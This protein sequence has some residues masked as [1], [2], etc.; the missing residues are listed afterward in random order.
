MNLLRDYR[1]KYASDRVIGVFHQD[2]EA[3][4]TLTTDYITSFKRLENESGI[5]LYWVCLPMVTRTALSSYE[6]YW[7]PCD[8][9][10]QDIWV[11]PILEYPYIIN[12]TAFYSLSLPDAS[13]RLGKVVWAIL[14]GGA[15]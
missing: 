4:Y 6:M 5:D 1:N 12:L 3:Q 15:W 13:G 8:D 10:K 9:T 7:Y 14:Q 2:F 11:R